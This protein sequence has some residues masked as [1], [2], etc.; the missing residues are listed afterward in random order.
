MDAHHSAIPS[1]NAFKFSNRKVASFFVIDCYANRAILCSKW[2]SFIFD[3]LEDTVDDLGLLFLFVPHALLAILVLDQ[4]LA[5][6]GTIYI[7]F[8]CWRQGG[9]VQVFLRRVNWCTM[10]VPWRWVIFLIPISKSLRYSIALAL[11]LLAPW[12]TGP[13]PIRGLDIHVVIA[14]WQLLSNCEAG[15][16]RHLVLLSSCQ[17]AE[18]VGFGIDT[19]VQF[20]LLSLEALSKDV[21]FLLLQINFLLQGLELHITFFLLQIPLLLWVFKPISILI[22]SAPLLF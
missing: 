7:T 4:D 13:I 15:F 6:N 12:T 17:T 3:S 16:T 8:A 19:G 21:D 1:L 20:L 2:L 9:G 14:L 22:S 5:V 11:L 18:V 10:V